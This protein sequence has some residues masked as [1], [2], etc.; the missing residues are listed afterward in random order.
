MDL[1]EFITAMEKTL[2][3]PAYGYIRNAFV[4][5][6]WESN[7]DAKP[8]TS[9]HIKA[10]KQRAEDRASEI[11]TWM[12][13]QIRNFNNFNNYCATRKYLKIPLLENFESKSCSKLFQTEFKLE[14][15]MQTSSKSKI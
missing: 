6:G 14:Y 1:P 12:R 11:A 7:G 4:H 9:N 8:C 13:D 2:T 15:P 5:C 10:R 3:D